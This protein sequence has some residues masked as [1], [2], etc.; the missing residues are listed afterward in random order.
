[1]DS[2]PRVEESLTHKVN[3][4]EEDERSNDHDWDVS[5]YDGPSNKYSK[6]S[7]GKHDACE[8]AVTA[9]AHEQNSI[10]VNEVVLS[11]Y[12][13]VPAMSVCLVTHLYTTTEARQSVRKAMSLEFSVDVDVV[14]AHGETQG[15]YVDRDVNDAKERQRK[16]RR[17]GV[18]QR[19]PIDR[20]EIWDPSAS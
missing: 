5:D 4:E 10:G 1:M 13:Y 18:C 19:C 11:I 17:Y 8:S 7:N 20:C 16:H 15:R 12:Q 3:T 2:S 6:S 14:F 9:T